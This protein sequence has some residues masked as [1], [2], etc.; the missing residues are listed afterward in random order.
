MRS[1]AVCTWAS[2][3]L[4]IEL[5]A[6]IHPVQGIRS[7]GHDVRV[8]RFQPAPEVSYAM[9]TGGGLAYAEAIMKQGTGLV[10][11][12]LAGARPDLTG[13]SCRWQPVASRNGVILSI[14]VAPRSEASDPG[15]MALAREL[16]S[17][18]GEGD[19]AASPLPPE[20]PRMTWPP[21]G[22]GLELAASASGLRRIPRL[23][24]ILGEQ[25]IGWYSDRTGRDVGRFSAR[26]YRRD[27]VANS[28]FRKLDDG[29]KLTLDV[30]ENLAGSIEQRLQKAEDEGVCVFGLHRQDQALVTCIVP[31]TL[32]RDHIHFIDGADGGYVAASRQL[33]AKL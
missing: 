20:G 4:Q 21:R 19:G 16:I 9:F 30:S 7:T 15:F 23:A 5:R 26:Q 25:L 29:L 10:T 12:A 22:L 8:A 31:S 3:E 1:A 27:L 6:A 24:H 32:T 2:E 13:L 33:K 28:D 11:P 18:A 14:L 17:L